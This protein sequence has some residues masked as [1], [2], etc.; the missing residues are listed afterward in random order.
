MKKYK[1]I[2]AGAVSAAVLVSA[3]SV[4]TAAAMTAV[5]QTKTKSGTF[6]VGNKTYSYGGD[7]RASYTQATASVSSGFNM[8]LLVKVKATT[9]FAGVPHYNEKSD[10]ILDRSASVSVDNMFNYGGTIITTDIIKAE[11]T[12]RIGT[13]DHFDLK[14][15]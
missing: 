12:Y 1:K 4:P 9:N 15:E 8:N 2:L 5:T 14:I 10:V 13:I 11:G 7:L 6:M 3:L